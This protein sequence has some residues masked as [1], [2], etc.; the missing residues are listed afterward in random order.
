MAERAP[1]IRAIVSDFGGVLTTPLIDGFLQLQEDRGVTVEEFGAAMRAIGGDEI[2]LFPLERGEI[3]EAEFLERLGDGFE[4]TLGRRPHLHGFGETFIGGLKP[5]EPMIEL[6]RELKAEGYRM[7]IL[8]NNVREWEPYWRPKLPIDEIFDLVIDSGFVGMRKPEPRIFELTVE[9][10]GV[11]AEGCLL[12]D[13]LLP[14]VEGAREFG[15][16]AVLYQEPD[17]A[18]AEIRAALG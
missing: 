9:R 1:G 17:Q 4:A 5:N 16:G 7:A 3:T 8:T 2:P 14:N 6:M 18:I 13:D 11:P 10:T 12:V 15:M